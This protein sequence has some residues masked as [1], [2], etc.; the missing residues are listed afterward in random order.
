ML[1]INKESWKARDVE[2]DLRLCN[3]LADL[4]R[5]KSSLAEELRQGMFDDYVSYH[6][7]LN[8]KMYDD[9]DWWH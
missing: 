5:S 8:R 1:Y 9:V 7:K 4:W 3:E 6:I 2:N